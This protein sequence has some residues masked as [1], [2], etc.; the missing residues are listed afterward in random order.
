MKIPKEYLIKRWGQDGYNK[1]MEMTENEVNSKLK[2][3]DFGTVRKMIKEGLK[4]KQ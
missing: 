3:L 4:E 2:R 1:F